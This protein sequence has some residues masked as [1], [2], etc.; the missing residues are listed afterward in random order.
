MSER[1]AS[2]TSLFRG[3]GL[4]S[5]LGF[6]GSGER[7]LG[8]S[9]SVCVA[10]ISGVVVGATRGRDH[11]QA[12]ERNEKLQQGAFHLIP[13]RVHELWLLDHTV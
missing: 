2:M 9:K 7:G 3:L 6:L 12:E 11:R 13:L 8:I 1:S 4:G 10:T 5:F